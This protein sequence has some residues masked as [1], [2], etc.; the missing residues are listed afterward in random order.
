MSFQ[1]DFK[2]ISIQLYLSELQKE[3]YAKVLRHMS[4]FLRTFSAF[5]KC[6]FKIHFIFCLFEEGMQRQG[7]NLIEKHSE[8]GHKFLSFQFFFIAYYVLLK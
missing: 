6:P 5:Y 8:F 4:E 2:N 1:K 3:S 7:N